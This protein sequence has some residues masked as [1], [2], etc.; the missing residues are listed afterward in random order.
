MWSAIHAAVP[1]APL[2][3]KRVDVRE[4]RVDV[5]VTGFS[6]KYT[7]RFGWIDGFS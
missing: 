2:A 1:G 3:S 6:S 7:H 5:G 4:I